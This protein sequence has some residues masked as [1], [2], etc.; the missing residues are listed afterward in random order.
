M[1]RASTELSFANTEE[2][3]SLLQRVRSDA[4]DL[5]WVTFVYAPNSHNILDINGSGTGGL[6]EFRDN[7]DE[8]QRMYGLL[9]VTDI[10][11]GHTTIKFVFVSWAGAKVRVVPKAKMATHKGS[12]VNLIGQA[13]ITLDASEASDIS[14]DV[15]M[16]RVTDASGSGSRVL[17]K[18]D[19]TR[20]AVTVN[21]ASTSSARPSVPKE[22]N[23]EVSFGNPDEGKAAIKQVRNNDDPTDWVLFGYEGQSNVIQ[24]VAT[25]N[26]G[27][28]EMKQQLKPDTINY[29]IVRVYDCYD[30]HTTT[31]F[32]LIL[33]VGENVK[34]MR[35]ARITTHKGAVLEFLGQYHTDIPCSNHDE[36]NQEII[37]T[38]VQ[39]ASGTAVHVKDKAE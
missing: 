3:E 5:S 1:P 33:W 38:A 12:I 14:D 2:A 21:K 6:G 8:S 18:P 27:I 17:D 10:I 26:G 35:K 36:V 39:D 13:H 9:R 37:M 29:G 20:A 25:G 23:A 34:I 11:D 22:S 19:Q 32:V 28:E 16:T 31:K 30:G 4:D 7:F 24:L 15:V